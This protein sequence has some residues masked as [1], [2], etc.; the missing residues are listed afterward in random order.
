MKSPKPTAPPSFNTLLETPLLAR[1][2][3]GVYVIGLVSFCNDIATEMVTPLIPILLVGM[4]SG[5]AVVLGLVEGLANAV[6][7]LLRL[8]AGRFSDV[9]GGRR[10]P[11]AVT[12]Y[13]ISNL[14]RPMLALTATWWQV[15]LVRAL[16]RVGKGLRSAPRD[17]LIVDLTPPPLRARAF[18][19]HSACDN[20][21]AVGGALIGAWVVSAFAFGVRDIVLLSAVPGAIAVVLFI[22]GVRE[23]QNHAVE[24]SLSMRLSWHDVPSVLR[25]YL[26]VV[27]LFT[28]ARTAELFVIFRASEL[29]ATSAQALVLWAAF[30]FIKIFANYGAG[31]LADRMGRSR[32]LVPGWLL[33]SVAMFAFCFV[34]S[35]LALWLV[36]LFFGFAISVGEGVERAVLGDHAV[37]MERGT[38]YG[39]YYALVGVASI[40]AGIGFGWVWQSAGSKSAYLIA[41]LFGL[42]ATAILHFRVAPRLVLR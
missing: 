20:L 34:E 36:T 31:V 38:I 32:L 19:I 25:E 21:G 18:G 41:A 27:M 29:G 4:T 8:W 10:K 35:L 9:S 23:P 11:L 39:W 1:V 37:A 33:Y 12:G 14:M 24:N 5:G 16:D 42:V 15:V 6:A 28:F 22:L 3:R 40:P 13:I 2:P 26:L 30:N 17:A 7:S